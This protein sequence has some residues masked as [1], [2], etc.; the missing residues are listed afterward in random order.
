MAPE[1][2]A[3]QRMPVQLRPTHLL[4]D[5]WEPTHLLDEDWEP[6][7]RIPQRID[8]EF[9]DDD[10]KVLERDVTRRVSEEIDAKFADDDRKVLDWIRATTITI[11]PQAETVN[12]TPPPGGSNFDYLKSEVGMN[13]LLPTGSI[14]ELRFKVALTQVGGT[15]DTWA[16]DGFPNSS[17]RS[18]PI[19]G[20]KIKVG[21]SKAFK[22]IPVIGDVAGE[23]LSVDLNPWTFSIGSLKHIEVAFS[24]GLT[25]EPD[26]YFKKAGIKNDEIRIAMILRKS[27]ATTGVKA[28][29]QAK[30]LYKPGVLSPRRV[31]TDKKSLTIYAAG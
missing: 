4:D 13:I 7:R 14:T 2:E 1:D 24:G 12:L 27:R 5:D 31:G 9:A 25:K 23:L 6:T 3:V 26:W 16:T 21:I 11:A 10:H 8:A 15:Q 20:G 29:V 18:A 30:W 17:I 28:D 22:L 19:V